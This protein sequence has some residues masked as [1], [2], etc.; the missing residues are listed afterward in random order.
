MIERIIFDWKRTL[1]DP[2]SGALLPGADKVLAVLHAR[3]LDLILIGKGG[4]DM[5]ARVDE[6]KVRSYFRA[7]H[8]VPAKSDERFAQYVSKKNP[9][10]T[11]VVGD[12]A[13]GEVAI[14]KRLGAQAIWLRAGE[15]SDELPL[16]DASPDQIILDISELLTSPLLNEPRDT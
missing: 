7:I 16:P 4:S 6:L 10:T 12:R 5:D 14:G 9:E 3:S 13:Q 15:F 1:Y 8:F 11:L 2:S